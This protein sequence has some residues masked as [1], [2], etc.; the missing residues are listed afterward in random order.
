M[1]GLRDWVFE[2]EKVSRILM[3]TKL[4]VGVQK[5]GIC[6]RSHNGLSISCKLSAGRFLLV[7][8]YSF[9]SSWSVV[10]I[11]HHVDALLTSQVNLTP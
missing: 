5:H 2:K 1:R 6:F 8:E 9:E 7:V 4:V 10:L 3:G 11:Q